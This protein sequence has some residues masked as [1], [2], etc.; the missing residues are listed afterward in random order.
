MSVIKCTVCGDDVD[1]HHTYF[2]VLDADDDYFL[3]R[4]CSHA[5]ER[6]AAAMLLPNALGVVGSMDCL[7]VLLRKAVGEWPKAVVH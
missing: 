7:T 4:G 3:V 6:A 5:P 2:V 1:R